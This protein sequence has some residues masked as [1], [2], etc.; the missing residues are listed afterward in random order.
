MDI[1]SHILRFRTNKRKQDRSNPLGL[2]GFLIAAI[3]SIG[4][5]AGVIFSVNRYTAITGDLP[6]PVQMEILLNPPDGSLLEPTRIFDQIGQVE[7]WRFENPAVDYRRYTSITDGEMLFFS[8][9]PE[10]LIQATLAAID[11]DYFQKPVPFLA[12]IWDAGP[13]PIPYT[14]VEELLLWHES[15]HPYREI[16]IQLLADQ[17]VSRY[18]RE[19]V[20]EWYLNSAYYGNQI[21]G[22][23]QAA[24]FYFGRELKSLDLAESALLAAVAKYPSLNPL[25]APTAAKENQEEILQR[26]KASDLITEADAIRAARKQLF[27][28]DPEIISS[29]IRPAYVDYI[30]KEA[31]DLIPQDRLLRGGYKIISTLDSEL[32]ETLDCTLEVLL[33]RV[34][35]EENEIGTSCEASRLLPKY[36]G[37][38]LA[39]KESLE[40]NI[41][42][43]DP[44]LGEL[45]GMAGVSDS[46]QELSLDNP[47]NPGTLITP[48]LYLTSF[49]R[50]SEPASLAWDISLEGIE[51]SKEDLHPGCEDPCDYQGPVNIR[52]ALMNDYLSPAR[53]L[54]NSR[55]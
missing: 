20:L 37:L 41:L 46:G 23:S 28:A 43:L 15:D 47:R 3:L 5:A 42:L 4:A 39:D 14:L 49:T 11:L 31:S 17:I 13:D 50:G 52:T 30:L 27:Y 34:T 24:R 45:R 16:R 26:M 9:A 29:Q 2:I 21:Y 55:G 51:L 53:Q 33:Q 48:F 19:K 44:I 12:G 18:G 8:D 1:Q 40:I 36:T 25:D 32:Q 7:L 54:W 38:P 35:G 6:S 22:A 10:F